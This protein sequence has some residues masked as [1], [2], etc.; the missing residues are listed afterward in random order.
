MG[1]VLSQA[2]A[3][4]ERNSLP[5]AFSLILGFAG[6]LLATLRAPGFVGLPIFI[7]YGV[8]ASSSSLYYS[9]LKRQLR[10]RFS[11]STDSPGRS[12]FEVSVGKY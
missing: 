11:D 3:G 1:P 7:S 5:W 10:G 12:S 6:W 2:R 4:S 9:Y 8:L